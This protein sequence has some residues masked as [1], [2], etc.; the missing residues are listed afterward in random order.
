MTS[1]WAVL[2]IASV[3]H[4]KTEIPA[5]GSVKAVF[6]AVVKHTVHLIT[7]CQQ[8]SVAVP[9]GHSSCH[10]LE[11]GDWFELRHIF[12]SLLLYVSLY[13]SSVIQFNAVVLLCILFIFNNLSVFLSE[14]PNG[15]KKTTKMYALWGISS[16]RRHISLLNLQM[17]IITTSFKHFWTKFQ[18]CLSAKITVKLLEC[19]C[20]VTKG[21]GF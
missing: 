14:N 21:F 1:V 3:M 6:V 20:V 18:W 19:H 4:L 9:F 13:V 16:W 17:L 10:E 15:W 5:L 8:G 2:H 7:C 12:S 11:L